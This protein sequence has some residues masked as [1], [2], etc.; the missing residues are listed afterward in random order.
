VPSAAAVAALFAVSAIA[1]AE[2]KDSQEREDRARLAGH[3][4]SEQE[5]WGQAKAAHKG[6]TG[7]TAVFRPRALTTHLNPE[8]NLGISETTRRE[9]TDFKSMTF[10]LTRFL[11]LKSES[12]ES[13]SMV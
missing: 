10:R 3:S 6:L 12:C 7:G 9:D 1:E 4:R 8:R 5:E 2:G 11:L 13:H